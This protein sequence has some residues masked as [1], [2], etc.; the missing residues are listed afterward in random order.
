LNVDHF[1]NGDPIPEARTAEEWKSASDNGQPAWCYYNNDPGNERTYGRLY[2]WY[3][4]HDL[5]GLAPKGWHVPS[6]GEWSSITGYL[7]EESSAGLALKSISGWE[8][9]QGV[10]GNGNNSSGMAGLPGG[11]RGADGIFRGIGK[12]SYWWSS[13]EITTGPYLGSPRY[14]GLAFTS[15]RIFRNSF[16]KGVGVSVRC[17]RD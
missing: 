7:G 9:F 8:N 10:S 17:I 13:T 14:R 6:D 2:N 12:Y 15:G 11:S 16:T 5:R 1:A 3:A 4:V